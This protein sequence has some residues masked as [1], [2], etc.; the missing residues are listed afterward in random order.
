MTPIKPE[1][2]AANYF[3]ALTGVRA[4]AAFMVFFHHFN[5]V[6]E[7]VFGQGIRNF[8]NEFHIGVTVFFVL[9][10]FLIAYRYL[11][12]EKL[13]FRKYM[14]NRIARIYP[15]YFILTSATFLLFFIFHEKNSILD[16]A[17]YLYN[18]S[19]LKGFF[20]ELKFSG[21]SQG[22]SLTVEEVFYLAAPLFFFFIRKNKIYLF[23][24]PCIIISLGLLM[25]AAFKNNTGHG[26]FQNNY[27]LF[28]YTFLGRCTEFFI[29]IS[30]ALLYKKFGD[31]RRINWA[32]Y[33]GIAVM[34]ICLIALS[35]LKGDNKYGIM[36][37]F[38]IVINNF[39]LPACGIALLFW[40]LLTEKTIIQ[41][42]LSSRLFIVLGKS[43]YLFYLIHLGIIQQGIYNHVTTNLYLE[44]I[45]I[46]II[47]FL[48]FKTL[49][50]PLNNYIRKRFA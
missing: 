12:S 46:N 13:N 25:V 34:C 43:S 8:V 9:S 1:I 11:D 30:L 32:T 23:I 44:F 18:I 24:L 33:S 22:W 41:K 49:E 21:I 39:I 47:A 48:L 2:K 17:L 36:H 6:N 14:V 16:L 15:M 5:P 31:V 4:I 42:I 45:L 40:G 10:G 29:G 38:G 3:P 27:F 28:N 26:F 20:N 50:E 35:L 37:P 19:F 7:S